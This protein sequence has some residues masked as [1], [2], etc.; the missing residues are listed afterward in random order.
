MYGLYSVTPNAQGNEVVFVVNGVF[1]FPV[2]I[3]VQ[4]NHDGAVIFDREKMAGPFLELAL[5]DAR[6]RYGADA[7][8]EVESIMGNIAMGR[9]CYY[10]TINGIE[11][12]R[13]DFCGGPGSDYSEFNWGAQRDAYW[14]TVGFYIRLKI[15][16]GIN[17]S[18][19]V[20]NS[21]AHIPNSQRYFLAAGFLPYNPRVFVN[22]N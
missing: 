16:G 12:P 3:S 20:G 1:G 8:I 9:S 15:N 14:N 6:A 2:E 21:I 5:A 18:Y 22:I 17:L 10:T 13:P 19:V 7:E 11:Q 4:V